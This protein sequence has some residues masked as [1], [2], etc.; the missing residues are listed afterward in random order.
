MIELII[1]YVSI[2]AP[3]LVA[4]LGVVSTILKARSMISEL[5]KDETI[6]ELKSKVLDLENKLSDRMSKEDEL[7]ELNKMLIDKITQIKGYA[8]HK[9]KEG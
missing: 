9:K 5:S 2:W 1:Q 8:D 6:K 3:S 4:I 7:I